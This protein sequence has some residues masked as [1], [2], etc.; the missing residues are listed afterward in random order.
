MYPDLPR[1]R[2]QQV[3]YRFLQKPENNDQVQIGREGFL[4][5]ILKVLLHER[6]TRGTPLSRESLGEN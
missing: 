5:K 4:K 1:A 2:L 3:F 6:R